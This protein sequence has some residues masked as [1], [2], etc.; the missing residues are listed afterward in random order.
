M[1][2]LFRKSKYTAHVQAITLIRL[3]DVALYL[4]N[5]LKADLNVL[6]EAKMFFV[7]INQ[8]T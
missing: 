3:I 2:R 5:I 4:A 7:C 1:I 8:T 6:K